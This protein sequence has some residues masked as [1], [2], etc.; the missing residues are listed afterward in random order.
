MEFTYDEN[1]PEI[2]LYAIIGSLHPKTMRIEG[3]IGSQKVL[4]LID[5]GST[6]NFADT[7]ICKKAHLLIQKE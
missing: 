7:S 2:S 5:S 6:H 3:W 4:I 1:F